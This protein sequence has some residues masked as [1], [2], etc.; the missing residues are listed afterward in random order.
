[1]SQT[2]NLKSDKSTKI[3][4]EDNGDADWDLIP[5]SETDPQLI[6]DKPAEPVKEDQKEIPQPPLKIQVTL[7]EIINPKYVSR[8]TKEGLEVK[9]SPDLKAVNS[10]NIHET[11]F[12][13]SELSL[14]DQLKFLAT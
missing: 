5:E 12:D 7:A 11:L 1:M 13:L 10:D 2:G 9:K 3:Q 6:P 8:G 14:A 4:N